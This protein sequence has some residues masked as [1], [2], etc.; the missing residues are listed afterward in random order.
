ME[1][2]KSIIHISII[3]PETHAY[4]ILSFTRVVEVEAMSR[5]NVHEVKLRSFKV[6]LDKFGALILNSFDV[7]TY[8]LFKVL[9]SVYKQVHILDDQPIIIL[10]YFFL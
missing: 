5:S 4:I 6:Y 1:L 10:I 7:K 3:N 8:L 9:L 2:L